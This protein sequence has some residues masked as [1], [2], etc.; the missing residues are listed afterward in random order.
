MWL[1]FR[2]HRVA[3]KSSYYL[4]HPKYLGLF[5]TIFRDTHVYIHETAI[6]KAILINI[7]LVTL[8]IVISKAKG[9]GRVHPRTGHEGPM[10]E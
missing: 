8:S 3:V 2:G 7:Y 10:G 5:R 6:L 1:T 9:K 4:A